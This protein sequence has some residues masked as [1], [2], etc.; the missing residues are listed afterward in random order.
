MIITLR[1][2]K[3]II[4]KLDKSAFFEENEKKSFKWSKFMVTVFYCVR[5]SKQLLY[6]AC[7]LK[8]IT[9]VFVIRRWWTPQRRVWWW[10][11]L[12]NSLVYMDRVWS[13]LISQNISHSPKPSRWTTCWCQEIT[14]AM[15]GVIVC[16]WV[17]CVNRCFMI[18]ISLYA[19]NLYY[20]TIFN[21]FSS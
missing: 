5:D 13:A 17:M 12:H 16:N 19:G 15:K 6:C 3:K 7:L 20:I 11:N 9:M 8:W 21:T 18:L 14:R 4:I 2:L 1:Y 10:Q